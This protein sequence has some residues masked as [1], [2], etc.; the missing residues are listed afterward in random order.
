MQTASR[1]LLMLG[2][3]VP[4]VYYGTQLVATPFY[5]GYDFVTQVAS[6]LGTSES[7]FPAI[8]NF[9]LA[10]SG[11]LIVLSAI[12][13]YP[14]LHRAGASK[15]F[16]FLGAAAQITMGVATI[17]TAAHPLPSDQHVNSTLNHGFLATPILLTVLFWQLRASRS[18]Q[19]Y[20]T[21]NAIP[22]L[23]LAGLTFGLF[24]W[25]VSSY[26]GAFQR[27]AAAALLIP[28]AI[29]CLWVARGGSNNSFKPKPLRG[30]A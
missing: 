15:A 20:F 5:P 7:R 12:A 8:F 19:L 17:W 13:L 24:S 22:V 14:G 23:L 16:S 27:A 30:S 1:F 26:M 18:I 6:Q 21:I 2:V 11:A 25:D 28:T 4:I 3:A 29:A 9:G 10:L